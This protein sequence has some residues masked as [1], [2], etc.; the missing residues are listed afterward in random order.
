MTYQNREVSDM[1]R[2][3]I[4]HILYEQAGMP[5]PT[6]FVVG[7]AKM[8]DQFDIRPVMDELLRIKYGG[9]VP[10]D[11]IKKYIIKMEQEF[12]DKDYDDEYEGGLMVG[13]KFYTPDEVKSDIYRAIRDVKLDEKDIE[14]WKNLQSNPDLYGAGFFDIVKTILKY[15]IP[16][17]KAIGKVAEVAGEHRDKYMKEDE[18]KKEKK[19]KELEA[20]EKKEKEIETKRKADIKKNE[21]KI[22]KERELLKKE[23]EELRKLRDELNELK[24]GMKYKVEDIASRPQKDVGEEINIILDDFKKRL[25]KDKKGGAKKKLKGKK[26]KTPIKPKRKGAKRG[27]NAWNLFVKAEREREK[28]E[29]LPKRSIAELSKLYKESKP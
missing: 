16:V 13:G 15:A 20:K 24:G 9:S 4:Y 25:T 21:D 29:N 10:H 14:K 18:A 28:S 11:K 8:K 1:I 12:E 5:Y 23:I 26:T 2:N 27:P 17:G 3:R 7:G 22:A 6:Q 19:K